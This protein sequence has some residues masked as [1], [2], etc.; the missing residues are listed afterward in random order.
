[1]PGPARVIEHRPSQRNRVG[2]AGGDDGL[3][4][5][6]LGDQADRNRRQS[7][8]VFDPV[9][10]RHLVARAELD[11][12][13]RRHP[14]AGHMDC[15]AAARLQRVRQGQG[16]FDVPAAGHPI[17]GRDARPHRQARREGLA[18][19][20]EHLERKTHAVGQ[21][22]A[23]FVVALVGDRREELVQQVAVR[24]VNFHAVQAQPRSA[25]RRRGKLGAHALQ[26]IAVERRRC[27]FRGRMR[28]R[29]RCHRLPGAGLACANLLPA[30]PRRAGRGLAPG[31][32]Q[33][34]ADPDRRMRPQCR[35]HVRQAGLVDVAV[36]TQ[37]PCC[38]APLGRHRRGLQD[39]Q[40]GARQRQVPEVHQ[41][42]VTRRA[43]DGRVLA[44][45]RDDDAV[46]QAQVADLQRL[47]QLA[48]A[49]TL[50][51]AYAGPDQNG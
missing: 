34:H 13:L 9:R 40:P 51:G 46:V 4:L 36:K 23:V 8:L 26:T 37:I 21:A 30:H 18:H 33:L 5:L 35:Q 47:E 22:A 25:Q 14:A 16:A 10:K 44:H 3:G 45:R 49:G 2:L 11:G 17:G 28:H 38:D 1:M 29:R 31:V 19:G 42:P 41:V 39:Q 27:V 24:G 48:H 50:A 43:V 20:L 12:L 7:D 15:R 32:G 6:G